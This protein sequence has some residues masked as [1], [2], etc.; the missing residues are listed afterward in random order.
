MNR[1]IL[2][3]NIVPE[4]LRVYDLTVNDEDFEFLKSCHNYYI[5][6]DDTPDDHPVNKLDEWLENKEDRIVYSDDKDSPTLSL[7]ADA[8]LVV[9]GFV[10]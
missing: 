4:H 7:P 5:N 10:L 3:Y 6:L 8:T 2:V 1:V 9:S